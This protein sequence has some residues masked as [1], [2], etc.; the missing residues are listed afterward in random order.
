MIATMKDCF[1]P[2]LPIEVIRAQARVTK[3]IS[4]EGLPHRLLN[5]CIYLVTTTSLTRAGRVF[6]S[7]RKVAG[8]I[9]VSERTIDRYFDELEI[10]GLL[11][12]QTRNRAPGGWFY[13]T[14]V[15]WSD[16]VW[17]FLFV[18]PGRTRKEAIA[19]RRAELSTQNPVEPNY[20]S[21]LVSPNTAKSIDNPTEFPPSVPQ[22]CT[23]VADHAPNLAHY[24]PCPISEIV[25]ELSLSKDDQ[26]TTF[27]KNTSRKPQD[28]AAFKVP[29]NIQPWAQRLKLRPENIS[30][31][32]AE[33]KKTDVQFTKTRLQDLLNY[34]GDRL[35]RMAVQGVEASK[36][37][38]KCLRSGEDYSTAR[39]N[40]PDAPDRDN[41]DRLDAQ[42]L[43]ATLPLGEIT[44][45]MGS[46][47]LRDGYVVRRVDPTY[48][49]NGPCHLLTLEQQAVLA[50]RAGLAHP[51]STVSPLPP[52]LNASDTATTHSL[53]P[54]IQPSL[55]SS[56][57]DV[58]LTKIRKE[59]LEL[60]LSI[61]NLYLGPSLTH[62]TERNMAGHS[63]TS[64]AEAGE[65]MKAPL[66]VSV[67]VNKYACAT[68][69]PNWS[70][71]L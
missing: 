1:D 47:L 42:L 51:S 60:P 5:L 70:T 6:L 67:M 10:G 40:T 50:R 23:K 52:T 56:P 14:C 27:E 29:A 35:M 59:F 53:P 15:R 44:V 8:I 36:Y 28:R 63:L 41:Q 71:Q 19:Q 39:F 17:N 61:Q 3:L 26:K 7:R 55:V 37:L 20:L 64:K 4:E 30:Y 43:H 32:M 2:N 58:L 24:S 57:K 38:F 33:A 22:T 54:P 65:W 66:L 13:G 25:K 62:L 45:V 9:G 12:R 49:L 11:D 34:V 68:Y 48:G 21:V 31:L 69:G 46:H 18:L 16:P